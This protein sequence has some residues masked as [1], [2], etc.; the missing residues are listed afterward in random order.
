MEQWLEK[1]VFQVEKMLDQDPDYK[2]LLQEHQQ[3]EKDYLAV[4]EKLSPE[5]RE[6]VERYIALCEEIEY[7]KT[8]TAWRCGQMK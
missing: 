8:H 5:D 3:A 1:G 7:Q 2:M 4:A 6:T